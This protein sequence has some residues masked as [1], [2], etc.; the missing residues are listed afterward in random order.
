MSSA[1]NSVLTG[2]KKDQVTPSHSKTM[3]SQT[4]LKDAMLHVLH[5]HSRGKLTIDR[6]W[7]I[8]GIPVLEE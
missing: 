4:F 1:Q 8:T 5:L 7:E 2:T 6:T 3:A